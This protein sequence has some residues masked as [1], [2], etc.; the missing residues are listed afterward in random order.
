MTRYHAT[1]FN[2]RMIADYIGANLF[3]FLINDPS[4]TILESST[5]AQAAALEITATNGYTRLGA[6]TLPGATTATEDAVLVIAN[7]PSVVQRPV[8]TCIAP[9]QQWAAVGGQMGPFTKVC[10]ARGA[11]GTRG[12]TSGTLVRIETVAGAPLT[13]EDGQQFRHTATFKFAGGFI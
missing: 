6:I 9:Q 1:Q 13:L 4:N 8:T 5:M 7:T 11:T 3:A 10:Y 2:T 12:N